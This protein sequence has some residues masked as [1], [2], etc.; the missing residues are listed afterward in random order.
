[1]DILRKPCTNYYAN[2][3]GHKPL[4]ICNHI[5]A[6]TMGSMDAWFKNPSSNASSTFGIGRS[7]EIHQYVDIEHGAWTQGITKDAIQHATAPLIKQ[8]GINPNLYFVGIEHEGYEGNGIDGSLTED[9]F[10]SSCWVH[11]YTQ[12]YV[13][14]RYG[15]KIELNP[16]YVLGHFQIDPRRKP[17]CPGKMF[18]WARLYAELAIANDMEMEA[19]D[20]RIEYLRSKSSQRT[21]AYAFAER[22]G[23]LRAKLTDPKW[24]D[25]ARLK[26][27]KL[28][29]CLAELDYKGEITA[30]GIASRVRDIYNNSYNEKWEGEAMR[31]LLIGAQC[32][33]EAGIL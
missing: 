2:R 6:G 19:Y 17:N 33:K 16:Y 29:P 28:T 7:G 3:L 13:Q 9:Q 26:L 18:P 15:H 12:D 32:A 23:D 27:L 8:M 30:E 21:T 5:S 14:K 20:E 4:A 25:V 31:K 1:M 22:I 11:K 10:L 24:G